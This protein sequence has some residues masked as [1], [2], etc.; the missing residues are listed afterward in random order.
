MLPVCP[1]FR[2]QHVFISYLQSSVLL[3][4]LLRVKQTLAALCDTQRGSVPDY[5]LLSHCLTSCLFVATAGIW[6][7]RASPGLTLLPTHGSLRFHLL[8]SCPKHFLH[9]ASPHSTFPHSSPLALFPCFNDSLSLL[10]LQQLISLLSPPTGL[11]LLNLQLYI[12][13]CFVFR[14]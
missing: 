10:K 14:P 13:F 11:N 5:I 4:S 1:V 6:L 8:D 12:L 3:L 7:P 2:A 9:I